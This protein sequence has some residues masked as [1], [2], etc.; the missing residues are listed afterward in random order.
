MNSKL[1]APFSVE[2][3]PMLPM[4]E[5]AELTAG[6]GS[7]LVSGA[8]EVLKKEN[9]DGGAS[10]EPIMKLKAD[11]AVEAAGGVASFSPSLLFTSNPPNIMMLFYQQ[12]KFARSSKL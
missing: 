11:D 4:N 10:V 1:E 3:A 2:A 7:G 6:S 8:A 9:A 5:N 12:L